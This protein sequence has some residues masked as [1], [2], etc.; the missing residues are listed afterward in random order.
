MAGSKYV[1]LG[2]PPTAAE[3]RTAT[4]MQVDEPP[5]M[6]TTSDAR[7]PPDRDPGLVS[8]PANPRHPREEPDGE[9]PARGTPDNASSDSSSSSSS[10]SSESEPAPQRTTIQRPTI[11]AST[12]R[13]P[14][15]PSGPQTTQRPPTVP[16]VRLGPQHNRPTNPTPRGRESGLPSD[17][18]QPQRQ[19]RDRGQRPPRPAESERTREREK[20]VGL[21]RES[22]MQLST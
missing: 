9:R 15:L 18:Q 14:G 20:G 1:D 4:H 16:P 10:S 8:G 7:P 2:A 22:P 19:V 5:P 17:S 6:D 11:P 3:E 13:G 12:Q 21:H